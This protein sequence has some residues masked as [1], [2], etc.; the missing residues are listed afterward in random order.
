MRVVVT[1]D[2]DFRLNPGNVMAFKAS[3]E[4]IV[5]TRAQ[6]TALIEAGAA[7]EATKADNGAADAPDQE[8]ST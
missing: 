8:E 3:P 6:G 1:K 4:A 2:H 5:V 7:R